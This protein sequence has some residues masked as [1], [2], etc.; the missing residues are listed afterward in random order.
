V[1]DSDWSLYSTFPGGTSGDYSLN[2]GQANNECM[3]F[4]A[5]GTP[6]SERIFK[7]VIT[8]GL[9]P[10][11]SPSYLSRNDGGTLTARA[12]TKSAVQLM[13]RRT[14]MDANGSETGTD[15][16]TCDS[17]STE[18]PLTEDEL[19]TDGQSSCTLVVLPGEIPAEAA[20]LEIAFTATDAEG[21][22]IVSS[23]TLLVQ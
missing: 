20:S 2:R 9:S 3:R 13:V 21:D 19:S 18:R 23:K 8:P 6:D 22:E 14:Y 17:A 11:L 16:V 12:L 10:S 1:P 5:D 15:E 7:V 4:V